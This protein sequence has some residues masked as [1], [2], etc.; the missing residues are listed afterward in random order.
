MEGSIKLDGQNIQDL[1]L[2]WLRTAIR[3]VQQV[4]ILEHLSNM[5]EAGFQLKT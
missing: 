5:M 4:R 3:L 1:N 2:R